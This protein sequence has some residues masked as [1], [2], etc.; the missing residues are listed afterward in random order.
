MVSSS[1]GSG[2]IPWAWQPAREFPITRW[3]RER[4]GFRLPPLRFIPPASQPDG[5]RPFPAKLWVEQQ[6]RADS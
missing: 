5:P 1:V 3:Q 4:Y 2:S 6:R